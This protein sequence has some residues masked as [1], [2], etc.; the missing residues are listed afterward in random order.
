MG[1]APNVYT[2]NAL[3]DALRKLKRQKRC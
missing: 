2:Y 1:C 3:L